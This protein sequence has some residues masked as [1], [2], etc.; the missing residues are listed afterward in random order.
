MDTS[1]E[2]R[3]AFLRASCKL[4][5][6]FGDGELDSFDAG[7]QHSHAGQAW[8][9]VCLASCSFERALADGMMWHGKGMGWCRSLLVDA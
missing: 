3:I 8:P 2:M 7:R 1:I 5:S 4:V 6:V 9:I